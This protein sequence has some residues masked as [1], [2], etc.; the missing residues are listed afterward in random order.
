MGSFYLLLLRLMPTE[1]QLTI[2]S[3]KPSEGRKTCLDIQKNTGVSE[4]FNFRN[5]MANGEAV[6]WHLPETGKI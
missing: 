6:P 2:V 5:Y 4:V 1:D 3:Y